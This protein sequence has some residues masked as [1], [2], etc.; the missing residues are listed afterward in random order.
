MNDLLT[1][2]FIPQPLFLIIVLFE[3]AIPIQSEQDLTV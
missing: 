1:K 2:V 3:R